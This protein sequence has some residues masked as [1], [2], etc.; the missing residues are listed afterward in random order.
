MIKTKWFELSTQGT[1]EA[2]AEVLSKQQFRR[3][4]AS[5]LEML[6]VTR[7]HIEGKFIEE[8]VETE[9]SVDPFGEEIRNEVRR[10]AI[11]SFVVYRVAKGTFL[12][13][14]ASPPRN[15][16]SFV[17][18]LADAVG[19]GLAV[20]PI[21]VEVKG[22]VDV[23]KTMPDVHLLRIRKIRVGQVKLAGQSTAR[24]EVV[25]A[26]DAFADL[27]QT[28]DVDGS[29]VEKATVEFHFD[30][31]ARSMEITANGVLTVDESLLPTMSLVC[32][33][34]FKRTDPYAN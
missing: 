18:F 22:F 31:V 6:S 25:S 5:G 20:A 32:F 16:R 17:Q 30:G 3:G 1:L 10:F 26:L 19:F 9:V 14:V 2:L 27:A 7:K 12:L 28:V 21:T 11:F 34:F 33:E 29:I 15:L 4:A 8:F 13:R 24:V 23:V